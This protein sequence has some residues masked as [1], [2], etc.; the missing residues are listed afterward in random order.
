[1]KE[2]A[3]MI[4]TLKDFVEHKANAKLK[5]DEPILAWI[6]EYVGILITRNKV[7]SDGKTAYQRLKGKRATSQVCSIG[8]KVLYMPVKKSGAR[9]NKLVPRFKY[10]VW[11]GISPRTSESLAGTPDGAFRT[12]VVRRLEESKRWDAE[13]IENIKGTPWDPCS[14]EEAQ[15]F[16]DENPQMPTEIPD[17][18]EVEIKVRR[19]KIKKDDVRRFGYT[20]GCAG[21]V[22]IAARETPSRS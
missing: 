19:M 12:R 16:I 13:A 2:L 21:C 4:R 17:P 8:E 22:A 9:L 7:G 6:I 18:P 11:L 5:E 20:Q 10:G 15:T 14:Q 3:G 1:M